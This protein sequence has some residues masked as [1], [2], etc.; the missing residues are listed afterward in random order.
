MTEFNKLPRN[1]RG[2]LGTFSFPDRAKNLIRTYCS[3]PPTKTFCKYCILPEL[4]VL[5]R[6]CPP[7]FNLFN[8]A[9]AIA[10]DRNA[11]EILKLEVK[12]IT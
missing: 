12:G 9:K 11:I 2:M 10:F 4:P 8:D 5:I 3:H 7:R 1:L 6:P